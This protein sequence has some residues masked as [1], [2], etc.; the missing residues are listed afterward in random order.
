MFMGWKLLSLAPESYGRAALARFC[1]RA[2]E[3]ERAAHAPVSPQNWGASPR[4]PQVPAAG[5]WEVT[6][7]G[8]Y[9]EISRRYIW[10][11]QPMPG[12]A[13][14]LQI[15]CNVESSKEVNAV[16]SRLRFRFRPINVTV[17]SLV[18]GLF[19][20]QPKGALVEVEAMM[21]S[22]EPGGLDDEAALIPHAEDMPKLL[23]ALTASQP[24]EFLL[25]VPMPPER[26]PYLGDKAQFLAGT[27]LD[28][29]Q[30]FKTLY[31]TAIENVWVCQDATRVRQ[32]AEGWYRRRT[33]GVNFQ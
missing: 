10:P 8:H 7:S 27:T 2:Q 16:V 24:L 20:K 30:Q 4:Q 23:R 15:I 28:N 25:A 32:L 11:H 13:A 1:E 17:A 26:E 9:F 18:L 21:F 29:D 22:K 6:G 33:P 3:V 12:R 14:E 19:T 31:E 5:A